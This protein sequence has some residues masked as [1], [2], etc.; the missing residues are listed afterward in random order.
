MAPARIRLAA[1]VGIVVALAAAAAFLPLRRIP[2]AVR[3]LGAWGPIAATALGAL[4]LA[5]LDRK[6]VV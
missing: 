5:A 1:L 6:S 3:H 4:L 2:E